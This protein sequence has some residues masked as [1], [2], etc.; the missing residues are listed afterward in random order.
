M[1]NKTRRQVLLVDDHPLTRKGLRD[2]IN[3]EPD[4]EVCDEAEGRNDALAILK[5][6][7]PDVVVLDLNLKDGNGWDLLTFLG[8]GPDAPPVL[9]LSVCQEEF[10]ALRLVRAGAKGYLMKDIPISQVLEAIRKVLGGHIAVSDAM[11][12][13]MIQA[14]AHVNGLMSNANEISGLSDR[15]LQ[16]FE[17]LRQRLGNSAIAERLGVS[18][19]SVGTYKARIM[20]KLGVRT[21]PRLLALIQDPQF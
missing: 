20:E 12:S 10:Y 9:I 14:A 17:L 11:A 16:V 19:K 5:Q 7:R 18:P 13:T 3:A 15:E 6:R 8:T 4:L 1:N 21:T 2:A